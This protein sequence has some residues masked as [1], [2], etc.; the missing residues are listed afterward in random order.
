MNVSG[1]WKGEYVFEETK[2][3]GSRLVVGT[4]VSYTMELKQGWLGMFTG[5][6]QE[7]PDAGFPEK[8]AIKGRLKGRVVVFEKIMPKLRMI[9]EKSR[10]TLEQIADRH[11]FVIDTDAPHPQIRHIGDVSEDEKTIEGTWL[12][13]EFKVSIPGSGQTLALPK[14]AGTWKMSRE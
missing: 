6:I 8:G 4:V 13:P 12:M 7:D 2:D 10:M 14:L 1:T 3:G 11:G 9:H 5:T